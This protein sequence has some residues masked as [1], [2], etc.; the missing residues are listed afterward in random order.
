MTQRKVRT[1]GL[2]DIERFMSFVDTKN[3]GG[4]WIWTGTKTGKGYGY[5]CMNGKRIGAHRASFILHKQVIPDGLQ[6]CHKCD[7]P[8]CVNPDHLFTGT[9]ADNSRDA[10]KKGR[11][12]SLFT[13]ESMSGELNTKSK[14]TAN[15]VRE[16]RASSI[17]NL[18]A[19]KKYGVSNVLIGLI[20]RRKIWVNV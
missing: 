9:V 19:A 18:D 3:A 7:N 5:F 14:L 17:R 13:S 12:K 4:C 2:T 11:L 1:H 6:V 10:M 8:P 16:I 15:D 20:R